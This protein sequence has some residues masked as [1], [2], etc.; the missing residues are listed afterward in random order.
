MLSENLFFSFPFLFTPPPPPSMLPSFSLPTSLLPSFL[1]SLERFA[2]AGFDD[3]R[4]P[5]S[6]YDWTLLFF[7]VMYARDAMVVWLYTRV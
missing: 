6:A 1:R 7:F 4:F 3:S 2:L 5:A